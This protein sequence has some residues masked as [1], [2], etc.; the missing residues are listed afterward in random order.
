MALFFSSFNDKYLMRMYHFSTVRPD[1]ASGAPMV[2]F[3]VRVLYESL[4]SSSS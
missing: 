1:T 3:H 4:F 2:S